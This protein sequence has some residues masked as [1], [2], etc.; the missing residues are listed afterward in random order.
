MKHEIDKEMQGHV[1]VFDGP[2][3]AVRAVRKAQEPLQATYQKEVE[4]Y[5]KEKK[6]YDAAMPIFYED[7]AAWMERSRR[8]KDWLANRLVGPVVDP[9][10]EPERPEYPK[11]A[12][13]P[14]CMIDPETDYFTG[15]KAKT[16]KDIESFLGRPWPTA[17][18]AVTDMVDEIRKHPLPTP[19]DVRRRAR[20]DENDGEV[21]VDRV[22]HGDP[23]FYRRMKRERVNGP[24]SVTLLC[25]LET[26]DFPDK[27]VGVFWRSVAAIAV[28]DVLEELGY[29]VEIWMWCRGRYVYKKPNHN[30]FNCMKVKGAGEPLDLHATCDAL[31]YWFTS[32]A[33]FGSFACVPGAESIGG[34]ITS[35]M[36]GWAKYLQTE[37]SRVVHVPVVYRKEGALAAAVKVL[38]DCRGDD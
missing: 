20:W 34:G 30:Q 4:R 8:Y 5:N 26:C 6:V 11:P 17:V 3:D 29:A 38:S 2:L 19:Q 14:D 35:G 13:R 37:G 18:K 22:R 10:D 24:T 15:R 1:L 27:D 32:K 21:D 33:I 25:N 36:D 23:D 9:G 7:R 12:K 31:S 28:T 16:W